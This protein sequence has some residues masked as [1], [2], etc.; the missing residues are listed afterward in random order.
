M[1]SRY[2][3]ACG[4]VVSA[5]V[6]FCASCG[7]PLFTDDAVVSEPAIPSDGWKVKKPMTRRVKMVYFGI[8]IMLFGVLIYSF[9]THLP[10]GDHPVIRNQP[11]IA[12][13]SMYTDV[14]LN[15][16]PVAVAVRNG[17]ITF[18]LSDLLER[19]MI[20]FEYRAAQTTVPLLAYISPAG[21]LVTAFRM[22]EPCN[23]QKFRME[24][25]ELACGNCETRW[26]LNNLEGVQGSCQKYPPE[27]IP[28]KVV[29]NFVQID[30][31]VVKN[32]K[33]RI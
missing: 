16:T 24:G 13:A 26:K 5:K 33:T 9:T 28:S 14:S 11:E 29:G 10:G 30:E 27:P 21:K 32:W 3:P 19:T 2:C 15:A 20:E 23:S 22:C 17:K 18:S 7:A 1:N 25:T 8:A 12:M 6:K 4:Q 31:S